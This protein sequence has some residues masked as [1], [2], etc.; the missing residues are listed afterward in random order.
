MSKIGPLPGPRVA[1]LRL[2]FQIPAKAAS[3]LFTHSTPPT[4]FAYLEW[5]SPFPS[6]PEHHHLMY[7]ISRSYRRGHRCAAV[8]PITA[9]KRSVHLFPQFGPTVP[10]HWH[11]STILEQCQTFYVNPFIDKDMYKAL[12]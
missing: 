2:L 4:Q 12:N 9:I 3:E 6:E 5:F 10:S 7:R 11:A 8:V 1:Q